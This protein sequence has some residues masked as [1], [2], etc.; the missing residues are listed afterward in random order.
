MT[1]FVPASPPVYSAAHRF[2]LVARAG[3]RVRRVGDLT[4]FLTPDGEV[5]CR[6]VGDEHWLR[7]DLAADAEQALV[8]E[9]ADNARI[10]A[11]VIASSL[12]GDGERAAE[13]GMTVDQ[14]RQKRNHALARIDQR[15][16]RNSIGLG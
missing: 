4:E 3:G 14:Y 1:H 13:H 7:A 10:A 11:A 8:A 12:A 2:G 6:K 9:A 15:R 16:G 5:L